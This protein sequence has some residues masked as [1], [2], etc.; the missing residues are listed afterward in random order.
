MSTAASVFEVD[1]IPDEGLHLIKRRFMH[2]NSFM[3]FNND[4]KKM[5]KYSYLLNI[6]PIYALCMHQNNRLRHLFSFPFGGFADFF[7]KA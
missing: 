2:F 5:Y 3:K 4:C 7:K 1:A 6:F